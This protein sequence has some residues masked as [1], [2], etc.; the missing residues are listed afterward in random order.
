[1][2]ARASTYEFSGM[3]GDIIQAITGAKKRNNK[4]KRRGERK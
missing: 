2:G 1:L 3:L 4:T